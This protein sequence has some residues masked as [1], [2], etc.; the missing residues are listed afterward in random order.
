M[1]KKK[2]F[3][4]KTDQSLKDYKVKID[5]IAK[6]VPGV[7]FEWYRRPGGS[8]GFYYISPRFE[9]VYG[10]PIEKAH[11]VLDF[12]HPEDRDSLENAFED[13]H[14]TVKWQGRFLPP[15]GTVRWIQSIS[16]VVKETKKE[17]IYEG[18]AF[19]ITKTKLDEIALKESLKKEK[20]L[21]M[22]KEK[23]LDILC[24]G[25]KT[26]LSSILAST[27]SLEKNWQQLPLETR[28]ENLN[29]I[30]DAVDHL[31]SL[32]SQAVSFQVMEKFQT[33]GR[34]QKILKNL[35]YR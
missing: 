1:K 23:A 33:T 22:Y 8:Y 18:F 30:K 9:E 6:S 3:K 34:V 32:I 5:A 7:L 11:Q 26:P 27:Q 25:L 29:K 21:R 15:E 14:R 4:A 16:R 19:D 2:F 17:K 35:P 28:M 24:N 13:K 10:I 31:T 12:V 20:Q